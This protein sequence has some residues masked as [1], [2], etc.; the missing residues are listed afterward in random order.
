MP[1]DVHELKHKMKFAPKMGRELRAEYLLNEVGAGP[2]RLS[3]G[4]LA[5]LKL[6]L[7][8]LAASPDARVRRFVASM[9]QR[10]PGIAG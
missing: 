1:S 10:Y 5:K 7:V 3:D 4:T 8:R 6:E 9:E 2:R